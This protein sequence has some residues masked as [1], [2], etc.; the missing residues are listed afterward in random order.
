MHHDDFQIVMLNN[1]PNYHELFYGKKNQIN[2]ACIFV[3]SAVWTRVTGRKL[4]FCI[5]FIG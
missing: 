1:N 4:E 2:D 5:C 3:R